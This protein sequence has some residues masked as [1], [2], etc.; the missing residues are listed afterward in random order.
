MARRKVRNTFCVLDKKQS[1]L[2]VGDTLENG[3]PV[4]FNI[5]H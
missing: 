5:I 4:E 2:C 3:H 1:V